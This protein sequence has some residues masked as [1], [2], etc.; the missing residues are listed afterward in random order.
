MSKDQTHLHN[1]YGLSYFLGCKKVHAHYKKD[2]GTEPKS[3]Q[4]FVAL[5]SVTSLF[6]QP[7]N[8]FFHGSYECIFQITW[9]F[10]LI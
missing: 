5:L 4:Q 6:F 3:G 1:K 8:F 9:H 7:F 10:V 2:S